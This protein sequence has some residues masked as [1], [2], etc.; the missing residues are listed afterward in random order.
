MGLRTRPSGRAK[1][2]PNWLVVVAVITAGAL[3]SAGG[4][5]VSDRDSRVD[6][7]SPGIRPVPIEARVLSNTGDVDG[8]ALVSRG[9]SKEPDEA[10]WVEGEL[11]P[12]LPKD[13]ARRRAALD[14]ARANA[15]A[16]AGMPPV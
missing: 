7:E 2:F 5:I 15:A 13:P 11:V 8:A 14:R 12:P 9:E 6:G 1:L 10:I 4:S 16:S 3:L